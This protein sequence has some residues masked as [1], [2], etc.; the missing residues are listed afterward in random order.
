MGKLNDDVKAASANFA[1]A[2]Q[3]QSISD[4]QSKLELDMQ[5][6]TTKVDAI[7]SK[8]ALLL[9]VLIPS[10]GDDAKKG[11]KLNVVQNKCSSGFKA[12]KDDD[13]KEMMVIEKWRP[14]ML[15]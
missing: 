7:D 9:S 3:V 8:L 14:L 4:K 2:S 13:M 10:H 1:T 5:T 15:L 12:H 6:L 11:E